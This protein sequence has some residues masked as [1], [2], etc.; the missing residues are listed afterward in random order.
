MTRANPKQA[1]TL[2][3]QP[4]MTGTG[5]MR[6][7]GVMSVAMM[8]AIRTKLPTTTWQSEYGATRKRTTV[9]YPYADHKMADPMEVHAKNRQTMM[10][11][12]DT[13][14]FCHALASR[15]ALWRS[16]TSATMAPSRPKK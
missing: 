4:L 9:R 10:Q 6:G 2:T 15:Y 3:A 13:N 1:H 11:G 5:K 8:S 12:M 7:Y 14:K 16:M